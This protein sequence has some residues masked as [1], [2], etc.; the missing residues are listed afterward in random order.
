MSHFFIHIMYLI[1]TSFVTNVCRDF[2]FDLFLYTGR[3]S[4]FFC[5][6]V[7]A[8]WAFV[9]FLDIRRILE[10]LFK[11]YLS[12]YFKLYISI[13]GLHQKY[14]WV[15]QNSTSSV[16]TIYQISFELVSVKSSFSFSIY[17]SS[18]SF[19]LL[20]IPNG[21]VGLLCDFDDNIITSVTI[22]VTTEYQNRKSGVRNIVFDFS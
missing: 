17:P 1:L 19:F 5:N 6:V 22:L 16:F 18:P 11:Q 20:A 14:F 10:Y 8:L 4:L 21:W 3:I 2:I 7:M 9:K 15:I 13:L 12:A